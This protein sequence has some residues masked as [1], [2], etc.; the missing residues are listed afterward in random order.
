M[1]RSRLLAVFAF[2]AF[3]VASVVLAF[4]PLSWT[5]SLAAPVGAP[6]QTAK[7]TCSGPW[8]PARVTGPTK[9]PYP[10]QGRPCGSRRTLQVIIA[11]DVLVAAGGVW[12]LIARRPLT[13]EL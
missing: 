8:T 12:W 5:G 11:V 2:A 7:F 3:G 6:V 4:V 10:L 9:L 13:T 1:S